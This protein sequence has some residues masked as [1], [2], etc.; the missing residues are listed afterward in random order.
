MRFAVTGQWSSLAALLV[1]V[2]FVPSMA[3]ALGTWSGSARLFEVLYLILWYAGP[4]SR[5]PPLDYVGVTQPGA[6][7]APVVTFI[8]IGAG[9][10]VLALFGRLR[11]LGG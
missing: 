9:L 7:A 2:V 6:G 5:L 4:M 3:L 10:A 1:A 11:Q 8:L